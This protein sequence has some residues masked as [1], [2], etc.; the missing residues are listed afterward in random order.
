MKELISKVGG[1][2]IPESCDSKE[3]YLMYLRHLFAY[4]FAKD[5]IPQNGFVLEVGCGEGYGTN[6]LSQ[7]AGKIIGLDVDEN[8]IA[9]ASKKY[10][11][12]NCIFEV[13]DGVRIPYNDN[14]FDAVIS[15]QVIE[16]LQNDISYISEI[17]RV[18]KVNGFLILTTPNRTCRLKSGQ[19]P[20]NRFHVREY[21][22]HE[23]DHVLKSK[24]S[25]VKVWG[26]RGNEEVQ[27]I[28]M[29]R[30]R[31]VLKIVSFD[32]FNLRKLI[33]EPL[34]PVVI[35][36][37]RKIVRRNQKSNNDGDF[38]NRYSLKDFFVVKNNVRDSLD[39]LGICR[40][41]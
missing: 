23:L 14:T 29:E 27:E 41:R 36:V 15:F 35:K 24:F 25:D 5:M 32:Y 16:H 3:E 2:V 17:C 21:A 7:H 12:E 13:Y 22:P 19:K 18:L 8:T 26:I 10:H 4:Q 31:Q 20:W 6:L 34:K 30:V 39:L 11:S 28:E 9:H 33:P 37:L 38:L 1:R 40:K